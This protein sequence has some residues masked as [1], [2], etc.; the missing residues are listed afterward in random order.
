VQY[1]IF[2]TSVFPSTQ[3]LFSNSISFSINHYM[4]VNFDHLQVAD[5]K[6]KRN[7]VTSYMCDVSYD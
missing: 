3:H 1:T 4:F 6:L 5:T 2:I 7:C